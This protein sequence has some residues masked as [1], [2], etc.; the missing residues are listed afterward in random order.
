MILAAMCTGGSVKGSANEFQDSVLWRAVGGILTELNTTGEI[1]INTSPDYVVAFI[2][3]ELA[4]KKL[5]TA[6][7]LRP[8]GGTEGRGLGPTP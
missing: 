6:E 2:C 5:V 3:Q 7:A 4:A 1:G 8:R